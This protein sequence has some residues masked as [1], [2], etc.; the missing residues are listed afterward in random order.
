MVRFMLLLALLFAGAARAETVAPEDARLDVA[1]APLAAKPMEQEMILLT[2]RG[3]YGVPITLQKLADPEFA[4]FGWMQL[5]RDRWSEKMIGGRSLR[6]F[7][8]RMALFAKKRGR[9]A[10]GAFTHHL[11]LLDKQ[12]R[13]FEHAVRSAP[14][15]I[16]IARKPEGT[17]WWLPARAVAVSDTWNKPPDALAFGDSAQRT[18]TLEARGA[19]PEMLPP[20]PTM[21]GRGL[22]AFPDPEDRSVELTPE[23]PISTVTWRWT[24]RMLAPDTGPLETA[25]IEWFDSMARVPRQ[26]AFAPQRVA[27]AT[28]AAPPPAAAPSAWS[29]YRIPLALLAGLLLGL[30]LL[31]PGW[32][33]K[34]WPEIA[35]P[36][37][38]HIPRATKRAIL[39]A[40][41]ANDAPAMW[42]AARRFN[43][44]EV[45]ELSRQ[46]FGN[47]EGG[48]LHQLGRR[49]IGS[50]D[51]ARERT[52]RRRRA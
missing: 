1:I 23:G 8:R 52:S 25:S 7:E 50:K 44:P 39:K 36:F 5:G 40:A 37:H 14:L 34:P 11:T 35:R 3:V 33:L 18:I 28:T 49:I 51:I 22:V 17:G 12:G 48:N 19:G 9:L 47:A 38:P 16:E 30:A 10:I 26:I 41:R 32:R 31:L 15:S 2:I 20:A 46:V 4:D 42:R 27:L 6:V 43:A 21:Q 29:A 45:A 13:R 24:V